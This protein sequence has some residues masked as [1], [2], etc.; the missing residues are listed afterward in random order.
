MSGSS[1]RSMHAHASLRTL[2]VTGA[3][4]RLL[5]S[6]SSDCRTCS[7][8]PSHKMH[9]SSTICEN[10]SSPPV[11]QGILYHQ[12]GG[13]VTRQHPLAERQGAGGAFLVAQVALR[14]TRPRGQG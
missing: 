9:S 11:L 2:S 14:R 6:S 1:E 5:H 10:S 4:L 13:A 8:P 3:M 7:P 12:H